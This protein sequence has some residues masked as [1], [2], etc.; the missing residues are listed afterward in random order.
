MRADLSRVEYPTV[1]LVPCGRC[2]TTTTT[3]GELIGHY[4]Q[5]HRLGQDAAEQEA[6]EQARRCPGCGRRGGITHNKT[7]QWKDWRPH[8]IPTVPTPPTPLWSYAVPVLLPLRVAMRAFRKSYLAHAVS[9]CGGDA[10]KLSVVLGV[11][12]T[13]VHDALKDVGLPK[14][15]DKA[16]YTCGRCGKTGHNAATHQKRKRRRTLTG[17]PGRAGT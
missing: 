7:C 16:T 3:P 6:A 8:V 13:S 10:V 14:L 17:S 11:C 2:Q 5:L 12:R 4:I 1:D 15:G 9:E